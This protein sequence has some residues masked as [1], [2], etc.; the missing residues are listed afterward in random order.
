MSVKSSQIFEAIEKVAPKY[1]AEQW[2]NPG[3]QVGSYRQDV[4]RVLL[5]LDVT[6]DVVEEALDKHVDLIVSHH[7]FIF[8]GVK[9]ICADDEKGGQ[10]FTLVKNNISLYAAHTNLDSAELGLN[11]Y[12]ADQLGIQDKKPLDPSPRDQLYKLVIYTPQSHSDR[13]LKVLGESGAGYVGKYSHCTFR[14]VGKGTF[15]PLQG[16]RPFLGKVDEIATVPED[17][18]ETIIDGQMIKTIVRR[19]KNVHPYEEMAYDLFPMDDSLNRESNGLGK[20]GELAEAVT[21]EAFIDRVKNAL[22]LKT[23]RTAGNPPQKINRVALCTGSGSEFIGLAKIKRADVYV[24]G[25]IRYHE[26]QKALENNLWVIDA[27]HFGTEKMVVFLLKNI[28]DRQCDGVETFISE[29]MK[30]FIEIH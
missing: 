16:S 2:D 6:K 30:D 10:I 14:T 11:D 3:L 20:I 8:N 29:K 26:A 28:I 23:V 21:P 9:S 18:I 22:K 19:V 27:G 25:D 1:L 17:R 7:P 24:T 5:A 4:S 15:K 13:I 12:I